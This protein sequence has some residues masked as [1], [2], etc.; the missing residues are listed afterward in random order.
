MIKSIV[1]VPCTLGACIWG[2]L[3]SGGSY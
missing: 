3:F 1:S 2:I